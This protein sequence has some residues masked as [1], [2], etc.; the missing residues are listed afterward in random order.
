M[1]D[2]WKFLYLMGLTA[3]AVIRTPH[4]LRNARHRAADAHAGVLDLGLLCLAA[5]GTGVLPIVNCMTPWLDFADYPWPGILRGLGACVLASALWLLWRSH[6]DLGENWSITLKV[7]EGHAL[8]TD[9]VYRHVRHPMYAAYFLWGVAQWL[10]LP[11]WIAGPAHLL[12]FGLLY[13]VRVPREERMML[14]RFGDEYR[15][16]AARTGRLWPRSGGPPSP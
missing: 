14:D 7:R 8:V 10:M 5:L 3:A 15:A 16:Y 12:T 6:A 1:F 2:W 13:A 11:N 9:G 4:W